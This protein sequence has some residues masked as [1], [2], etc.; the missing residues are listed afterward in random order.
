M[1]KFIMKYFMVNGVEGLFQVNE[2][3]T[4][5]EALVYI[6]VNGF[7]DVN[8]TVVCAMGL[9]ETVLRRVRHVMFFFEVFHTI[10]HYFL[11]YSVKVWQ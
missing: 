10:V 6:S 8:N 7:N 4:C 11:K 3:S 2:D 1:M 9:M 5:K